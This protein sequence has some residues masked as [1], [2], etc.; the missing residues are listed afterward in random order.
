M[1][2]IPQG[3]VTFLYTDVEGKYIETLC[4]TFRKELK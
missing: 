2:A 3:N 1:Q 4:T